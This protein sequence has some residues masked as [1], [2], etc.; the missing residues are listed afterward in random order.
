MHTFLQI[1]KISERLRAAFNNKEEIKIKQEEGAPKKFINFK[2]NLKKK[3]SIVKSEQFNNEMA[4]V[5]H[6]LATLRYVVVSA[7]WDILSSFIFSFDTVAVA[8][9]V[10]LRP[11]NIIFRKRFHVNGGIFWT[12][13]KNRFFLSL[14]KNIFFHAC[15]NVGKY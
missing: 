8:I 7:S 5:S 4:D 12:E 10:L 3:V 1:A 6:E 9:L 13:N 2:K 15:W 11:R 14:L